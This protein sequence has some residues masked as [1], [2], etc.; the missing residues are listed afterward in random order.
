[1]RSLLPPLSILRNVFPILCMAGYFTSSI[2]CENPSPLSVPKGLSTL[3]LGNGLEVL[4]IENPAL[5]MVG[6]NLLV[7]TGSADEN[8]SNNGAS[9]MLEHLL[10]N[11]TRKR[12]QKQLYADVD[13]IGGYNN[14]N[15]GET[16]TNFML[17]APAQHLEKAIEI[18]SDMVFHSTLPEAKFEKEKGIVLE[19]IAKSMT[20]PREEIRRNL[21]SILFQGNSL[22]LPTLGTSATVKSLN[23]DEI[24]SYYK[25][26]YVPNNMLLSVIGNFDTRKCLSLIRK[27]Y[28]QI[29]PGNLKQKKSAS[30]APRQ[31]SRANP[32]L[33]HRSY[34][35]DQRILNLAYQLPAFPIHESHTVLAEILDRKTS[36]LRDALEKAGFKSGKHLNLGIWGTHLQNYVT[37]RI[38]SGSQDLRLLDTLKKQLGSLEFKL[39]ETEIS[40]LIEDRQ[41]SFYQNLEKPHM[42]GILNAP[43]L[44]NRGVSAFL[45]SFDSKIWEI[46]ATDLGEFSLSMKPI[47]MVHQPIYSGSSSIDHKTLDIKLFTKGGAEL[48]VRRNS[49]SPLLAMHLLFRNKARLESRFGKNASRL[50]H[51]CFSQR[52]EKPSEKDDFKGM[53][54]SFKVNDNPYFPM[55]NIYLDPSFGYI[56]FEAL[57][58]NWETTLGILTQKLIAF[59]P[60]RQEFERAKKN[61]SATA[62]MT[63]KSAASKLFRE[64]LDPLIYNS[65]ELAKAP[66]TISYEQFVH[67]G[68]IYFQLSNSIIAV[69]SP[70]SLD[71]VKKIILPHLK[72]GPK[73]KKIQPYRKTIELPQESVVLERQSPGARSYLYF[74]FAKEM[75]PRDEAALRALSLIL[76]EKITFRIREELGMAYGIRAGV[77]SREG[78]ALFS[79]SMGTRPEN[80]KKLVPQFEDF[81]DSQ[82]LEDIDE[83]DVQ[84]AINKY[85]GRMM[86]RRLSSINQAYYLSHS[87]YFYGDLAYD[88]VGLEQLSKV[89]LKD[90]RKAVDKYLKVENSVSIT[91]HGQ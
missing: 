66:E 77:E 70:G 52:L 68:E 67:F 2:F 8:L 88:R 51:D 24:Q 32:D 30:S 21:R 87:L 12:T 11:G 76:S 56:R 39:T 34:Q 74:G 79:I 81:F 72:P 73:K 54:L 75:N 50:F 46:A 6:L 13:R 55:D 80:V 3:R 84:K 42:F 26:H 15:T 23:R 20:S 28:G 19:E 83:V 58:K 29:R 40:A 65:P 36:E 22:S 69:V 78:R 33:V 49:G 48:I 41:T 62:H 89:T 64:T 53:G 16:Y 37:A 14:A 57:S 45:K 43:L 4:L 71:E 27:F 44:A 47:V 38:P 5:P 31:F 85:L 61:L 18:Q 90:L 86:F 82:F 63:K 91:V 7:K 9:H 60:S 35:G 25:K 59:K 1:M 10:F 17:V